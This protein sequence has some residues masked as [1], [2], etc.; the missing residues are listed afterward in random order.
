MVK[1]FYY[2]SLYINT[3]KKLKPSIN[4]K[5]D[6]CMFSLNKN[7]KVELFIYQI[8][9]LW[10]FGDYKTFTSL[11]L[12]TNV[13]GIPSPKDDIDGSEVYRVYYEENDIDRII[14]YCE[15]DTIAVA[16]IF[17]RL[18]GDSILTNEEI[19]HV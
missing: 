7:C 3:L 15:K 13:L 19:L 1:P 12:M 10:K 9:G 5:I 6:I 18:R 11:K 2:I 16:Q 14:T 17:L 8:L 4:F